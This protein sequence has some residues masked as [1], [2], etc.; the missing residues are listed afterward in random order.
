MKPVYAAKTLDM[1]LPFPENKDLTYMTQEEETEITRPPGVTSLRQW[2]CMTLNEGKHKGKTF[3][4]TVE[5]DY[6]YAMWMMRHRQLS[7]DWARSFQE[8]VK[9]WNKVQQEAQG[10]TSVPQPMAKCKTGKTGMNMTST[11]WNEVDEEEMIMVAS[12][13][14]RG[15]PETGQSST[16]AAEVDPMMVENLKTQIVLLQR[17]LDQLTKGT[18]SK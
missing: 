15:Y 6:Q 18:M 14:K 3:L 12:G 17:Q 16:M 5:G 9:A 8:F 10:P 13:S 7:S 11:E 2:G 1:P 4:E